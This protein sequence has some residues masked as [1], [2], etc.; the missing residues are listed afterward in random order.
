M[1]DD[2]AEDSTRSENGGIMDNLVAITF[3]LLC[4]MVVRII[5]FDHRSGD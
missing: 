2:K 1:R 4:C 5:C 3:I